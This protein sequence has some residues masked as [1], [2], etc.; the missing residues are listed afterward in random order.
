M[1]TKCLHIH[2]KNISNIIISETNECFPDPCIN[3]TC[4]DG[5]GTYTCSCH[6]KYMGTN[7]SGE[8]DMFF[9]DHSAKLCG[10]KF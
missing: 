2:V 9:P 5:D 6:D 4:T 1:N 3:G 7:C 8:L 10:T